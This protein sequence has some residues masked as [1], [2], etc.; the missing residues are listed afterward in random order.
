MLLFLRLM[1]NFELNSKL[2][3]DFEENGFLIFDKF[4]NLQF[5]DKLRNKFEPLFRG[6]LKQVFLQ[7][8]GT[9]NLE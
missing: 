3:N 5:L 7:M 4:I 2:I 6:N 9:G 1:I 8:N